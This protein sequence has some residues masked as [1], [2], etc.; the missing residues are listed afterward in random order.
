MFGFT[1]GSWNFWIFL[2]I[3]WTL[4]W[5]GYALWLAAKNNHP[6]WFIALFLLNTVA[7][8]EIIYIFAIGRKDRQESLGT[9]TTQK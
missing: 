5:K 9:T 7:I 8:L 6:R 3:L 2:L 4:P 1:L